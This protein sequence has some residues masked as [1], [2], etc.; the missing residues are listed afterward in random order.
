MGE[1]EGRSEGSGSL[2]GA[3]R[4]IER[5]EGVKTERGGRKLSKINSFLCE[6][7]SKN[8]SKRGGGSLRLC[9]ET[10]TFV[11][12]KLTCIFFSI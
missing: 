3:Y 9:A 10:Q 2:A 4:E 7:H 8:C 6:I 1:V 11:L 12:Q 5:G